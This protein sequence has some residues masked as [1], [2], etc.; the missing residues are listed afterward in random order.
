MWMNNTA[1]T[2]QNLRD[3]LNQACLWHRKQL[4]PGHN[5]LIGP[6]VH[7]DLGQATGL[8]QESATPQDVLDVTGIGRSVKIPPAAT[9]WM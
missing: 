1:M 7:L 4:P 2:Y 9:T 8:E 3:I 5:G 6:L